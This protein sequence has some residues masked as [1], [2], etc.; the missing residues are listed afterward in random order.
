MIKEETQQPLF[1]FSS[2]LNVSFEQYGEMCKYIYINMK[3]Q[4]TRDMR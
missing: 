3:D 4:E 2:S 1:P